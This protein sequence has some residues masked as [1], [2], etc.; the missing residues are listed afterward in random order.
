L[1]RTLLHLICLDYFE[2]LQASICFNKEGSYLLHPIR[3]MMEAMTV[4]MP[5]ID[6][7]LRISL[8]LLFHV[9]EANIAI[10]MIT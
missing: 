8:E 6:R 2:M 3:P 4:T 5:V 7:D 1:T 9:I 10:I